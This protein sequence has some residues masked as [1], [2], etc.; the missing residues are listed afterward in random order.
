MSVEDKYVILEAIHNPIIIA[1]KDEK[2]VPV[3]GLAEE[4]FS[5]NREQ[6]L[7]RCV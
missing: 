6:M 1:G 3:N 7:D 2:I 4:L 5:C